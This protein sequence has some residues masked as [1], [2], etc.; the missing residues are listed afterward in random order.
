[1]RPEVQC[2][3]LTKY[4][5]A[6]LRVPNMNITIM[7][8]SNLKVPVR[9]VIYS[10]WILGYKRPGYKKKKTWILGTIG[11]SLQI[12]RNLL[13][14]L[15]FH[16]D[17][18]SEDP[19]FFLVIYSLYLIITRIHKNC[20]IAYFLWHNCFSSYPVVCWELTCTSLE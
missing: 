12:F 10:V 14:V 20:R 18:V 17:S 5:V 19:G 11:S 15:F 9:G 7:I 4:R 8:W 1:M 2:W 13:I 6:S 3:V 16:S